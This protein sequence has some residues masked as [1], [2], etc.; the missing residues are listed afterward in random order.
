MKTF[1]FITL[2]F[3]FGCTYE[4]ATYDFCHGCTSSLILNGTN[5]N[6]K[7]FASNFTQNH[8]EIDTTFSVTILEEEPLHDSYNDI[9]YLAKIP[10]EVGK[11]VLDSI[12]ASSHNG[13]NADFFVYEYEYTTNEQEYY[14]VPDSNSFIEVEFLDKKTG[15]YRLSFNFTLSMPEWETLEQNTYPRVLKIEDGI[16]EG[17]IY[18]E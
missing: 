2:V 4:T 5:W 1:I 8:N 10:Y 6:S 13:T 16:A 17:Y 18:I 9:L 14:T 15:S 7:P 3:S 11:Y 12:Q